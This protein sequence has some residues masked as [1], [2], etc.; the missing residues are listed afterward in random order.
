MAPLDVAGRETVHVSRS[1]V[2]PPSLPIRAR[3]DTPWPYCSAEVPVSRPTDHE[4]RLARA[5]LSLEGL[6]VGDAFGERFFG[7]ARAIRA[8]LESREL[9]PPPWRY[10]DDTVMSLGIVE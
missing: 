4:T 5:R 3:A 1:E 7:P 6:S 2:M 9:P 10:T 8:R